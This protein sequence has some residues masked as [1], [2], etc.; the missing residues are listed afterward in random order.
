MIWR[1]SRAGAWTSRGSAPTARPARSVLGQRR[2]LLLLYLGSLA[3]VLL[4]TALVVRGVVRSGERAEVRS[5]LSLIAEDLSALPLPSPGSERDLQESRQDFVTAHQQLEWFRPGHRSPVARLGEARALGPLPAR[6]SPQ[7]VWQEG[8][9]WIA[10]VRPLEAGDGDGDDDRS[11][12]WLRISEGLMPMQARMRQLDLALATA[13]VLALS[14][15]GVSAWLLTERAVRPLQQSLGRLRQF[16]LDASHELRGPLAAL[17]ANA[18]MGLLDR[19]AGAAAQERRFEAVLS[20]ARQMERLVEDLL[21]LARQDEMPLAPPLPVD[22]SGLLEQLLQL[23]RDGCA[24]R[25]QQLHGEVAAGLVVPGHAPLLHR[26]FRNLLDNAQRYTPEGGSIRVRAARQGQTVSVAVED[27]GIGLTADQL[28][29]VF[30]RFWRASPDRT[31]EG[32]G[33]GLAIVSRICEV[34]GGRILVRSRPRE[35]TCFEVELPALPD[36]LHPVRGQAAG[37]AFPS[38]SPCP[39][40][41]AAT[42]TRP[43]RSPGTPQ[44]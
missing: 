36:R 10:L 19:E 13:V 12:V 11:R 5:R 39:R 31:A 30:E 43:G 17:S 35:G 15:S 26:L 44:P 42:G 27:S 14:L 40:T 29:R 28:P 8:P 1:L 32:S 4:V 41:S 34:H 24:L 7:P 33:L 37:S 21:L 2:E 38:S 16:S 25:S 18:E 20:A 6:P 23:H 22:L 3:G 9:D